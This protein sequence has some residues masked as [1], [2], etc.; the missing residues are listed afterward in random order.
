MRQHDRDAEPRR[1]P[2]PK[3][4]FPAFLLAIL[5]LAL[6]VQGVLTL[7]R[8]RRARE[9][10]VAGARWIWIE[11]SP[12]RAPLHFS[13]IRLFDVHAVPRS[14]Q[15]RIFVDQRF[16]LWVNGSRAGSGGQSPGDAM[17]RYEVSSLLRPGRNVIA[18]VAESARGIGGI[19][20]ALDTGGRSPAI[21]SDG[22]WTIDPSGRRIAEAGPRR[23]AVLGRPPMYPWGY[24]RPRS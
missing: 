21:V 6:G 9:I 19:L 5:V 8:A 1:P 13:A 10:G 22:S 23:A 15:A 17:E 20:F 4:P 3:S 14:A 12:D 2:A 11:Q 18:I 24:P 7:V 16:V